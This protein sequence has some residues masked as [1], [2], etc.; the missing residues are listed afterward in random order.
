AGGRQRAEV[1]VVGLVRLVVGDR[2]LCRRA[3]AR[4]GDVGELGAVEAAHGQGAPGVVGVE[5]R[6][7][8]GVVG[9]EGGAREGGQALGG[10]L[11]VGGVAGAVGRVE[12]VAALVGVGV[13]RDGAGADEGDHGVE[14][15]VPG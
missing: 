7:Q 15:V 13:V 6:R 4:E 9:G 11:E 5:C 3:L 10:V 12:Q 2:R 8:G 14:G 1:A